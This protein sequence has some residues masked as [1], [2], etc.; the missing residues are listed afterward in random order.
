M[1][2]LPPEPVSASVARQ[3]VRRGLTGSRFV[4]IVD[5]VTAVADELVTNGILHGRTELRLTVRESGRRLRVEVLDS[6]T[7]IPVHSHVGVDATSGRGLDIVEALARSWGCDERT[8]G[9]VVWC[10]MAA[11]R[12]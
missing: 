5:D 6:N 12:N 7:R 10:E 11:K 8:G 4:G 1:T 3:F 2:K 9:K